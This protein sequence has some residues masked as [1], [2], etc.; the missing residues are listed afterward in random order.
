MDSVCWKQETS[1]L[2]N[3]PITATTKNT[4]DG[5]NRSLMVKMAKMS[6]PRIKPNCTALV[7][8]AIAELDKENSV[9]TDGRITFPTNHRFV[10]KN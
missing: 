2:I 8:D 10:H 3:D 4:R 7:R 5:E 6:V 1:K 9:E